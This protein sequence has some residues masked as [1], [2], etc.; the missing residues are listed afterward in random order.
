M[1]RSCDSLLFPILSHS[2]AKQLIEQE[3]I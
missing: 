2:R 1:K 3:T